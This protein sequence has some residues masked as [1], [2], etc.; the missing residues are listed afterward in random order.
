MHA[1]AAFLVSAAAAPFVRPSSSADSL[2]VDFPRAYATAPR[3]TSVPATALRHVAAPLQPVGF[4]CSFKLPRSSLSSK[5]VPV[6]PGLGRATLGDLHFP[7]RD[8]GVLVVDLLSAASLDAGSGGVKQSDSVASVLTDAERKSLRGASSVAAIVNSL[9]ASRKQPRYQWRL[10]FPT[11]PDTPP[12]TVSVERTIEQLVGFWMKTMRR[13]KKSEARYVLSGLVAEAGSGKS[14]IAQQLPLQT[15]TLFKQ[16]RNVKRKAMFASKVSFLGVNFN[17]SFK[18]RDRETT[19]V[20]EGT[21]EISDMWRLRMMFNHYANLRCVDVSLLFDRYISGVLYA[22]REGT[23]QLDDIREEATGIMRATAGL[24]PGGIAVLVVDEPAKADDNMPKL[25]TYINDNQHVF[26]HQDGY[27]PAASE[28]LLGSMCADGDITRTCVCS[29]SL[30]ASTMIKA[31]TPSG[32]PV[33][34]ADVSR[35][36]PTDLK[37]VILDGL[38]ALALKRMYISRSTACM[39]GFYD[40]MALCE[41]HTAAPSR[42][43]KADIKVRLRMLLGETA[44]G[45]SYCASAHL[46]TAVY[47]STAVGETS[48]ARMKTASKNRPGGDVD[49]GVDGDDINAGLLKQKSGK[50]KKSDT[51]QEGDNY[52]G[53]NRVPVKD[54]L[55]SVAD[56][57]GMSV[58]ERYWVDAAGH[59][60]ALDNMLATVIL[61]KEVKHDAIC[62]PGKASNDPPI[63]WDLARRAGLVF[64]SGKVFRPRFSVVTMIKLLSREESKDLLFYDVMSRQLGQTVDQMALSSGAERAAWRRWEMFAPETEVSHSIARSL[65]QREYKAITLKGLMAPGKFAYLGNGELLNDIMVDASRPRKGVVVHDMKPLLA[66]PDDDDD[67]LDFVYRLP[68]GFPGIDAVMFFRCVSA[69]HKPKL[70]GKNIAAVVQ[71]KHSDPEADTY[72]RGKEVVDNWRKME[73][74]LFEPKLFMPENKP[75]VD[76]RVQQL[77]ET[78]KERIVYLNVANRKCKRVQPR[79]VESDS[80]LVKHCSRNAIV[81][82]RNHMSSLLGRT[83][84]DFSLG[85]DWVLGCHVIR[86]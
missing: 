35:D 51:S 65:K 29:T 22:L 16:Q 62:L 45:L 40:L 83:Y 53:G 67:V 17:S 47:V 9:G 1:T 57:V 44:V 77:R 66:L 13:R 78:W 33:D 50:N 63:T 32:R 26:K 84:R 71:Y 14:F 18:V 68:D 72:L 75:V 42:M 70:V 82:G 79:V 31:A 39:P 81:L 37:E 69:P 6:V 30:T 8:A 3:A 23:L 64:G 21:I 15:S 19:A 86:F 11:F 61:S 27:V 80:D 2:C 20:V 12:S 10:I 43:E 55:D 5:S 24:V 4:L 76:A 52:Q 56:D 25:R 74:E 60:R 48:L 7:S 59:F 73:M 85:M 49:T 36:D 54:I 58:A 34:Y 38:V 28:I 46:R 41:E